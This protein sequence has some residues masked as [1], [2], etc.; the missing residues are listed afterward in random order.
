MELTGGLGNQLFQ[1]QAALLAS[2]INNVEL[3]INAT[4]VL[5]THDKFGILSLNLPFN[6]IYL[7]KEIHSGISRKYTF[8]QNST[9]ENWPF[10]ESTPIYKESLE[11]PSELINRTL[12]ENTILRGYFQS[13]VISKYFGERYDDLWNLTSNCNCN[14][15]Q[16][17]K[18]YILESDPIIIHVRGGDY[19]FNP[20]VWGRLS[21]AYY[22]KA[23]K[24]L[25][26]KNSDS[27][28][29][30]TDD[31]R[32][33]TKEFLQ[34]FSGHEIIVSSRRNCNNASCTLITM[35][36]GKRFI[37]A[38]S[39][40]SWWAAFLS[41]S[42]EVV[43]PSEFYRT[44]DVNLERYPAVWRQTASN[45]DLSPQRRKVRMQ[46]SLWEIRKRARLRTRFLTITKFFSRR[47]SK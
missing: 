7:G 3:F 28:L 11:N 21:L 37:I 32:S 20:L 6:N 44:G 33:I 22:S 25:T 29:I 1:F 19:L 10:L 2:R 9:L 4:N 18:K 42:N 23:K 46:K 43:S 31:P 34:I 13:S 39:T 12:T 15:S 41:K 40:F 35:S 17:L 5:N 45:W 47:G 38:N 36:L 8:N 27:F 24:L 14:Y 16:R 26:Q 30:F